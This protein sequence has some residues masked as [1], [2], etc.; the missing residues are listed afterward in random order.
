MTHE[1]SRTA[2][3]RILRRHSLRELLRQQ[4]RNGAGGE[5]RIEHHVSTHLARYPARK[6]VTETTGRLHDAEHAH[7]IE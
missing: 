4:P 5:I 3:I 6:E 1:Q 2:R 7:L